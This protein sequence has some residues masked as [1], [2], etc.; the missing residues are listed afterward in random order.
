MKNLLVRNLLNLGLLLTIAALTEEACSAQHDPDAQMLSIANCGRLNVL[1]IRSADVLIRCDKVFDSSIPDEMKGVLNRESIAARVLFDEDQC[2]YA[3]FAEAATSS[4]DLEAESAPVEDGSYGGFCHNGQS[5]AF[6]IRAM[7]RT[8]FQKRRASEVSVYKF[9]SQVRFLDPRGLM[10]G[11]P[12]MLSPIDVE[13]LMSQKEF[14]AAENVSQLV[15]A[16]QRGDHVLVTR[17]NEHLKQRGHSMVIEEKYGAESL[18]INSQ[19]F[20][21]ENDESK[22]RT[23]KLKRTFSW[24]DRSGIQLLTKMTE[25]LQTSVRAGTRIEKG[26]RETTYSLD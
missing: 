9:L 11:D 10:A 1:G 25:E 22:A 7:G 24:E 6:A 8:L 14:G 18:M 16:K 13:T 5:E 21:L 17:K 26:T 2:K 3:F 19:F 15:S 20:W 4:L 23:L 12:R